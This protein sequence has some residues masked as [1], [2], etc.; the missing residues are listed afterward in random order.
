MDRSITFQCL[1]PLR[2]LV[3]IPKTYTK[4]HIL[5]E[6]VQLLLK[7]FLLV[8]LSHKHENCKKPAHFAGSVILSLKNALV[9]HFES[10]KHTSTSFQVKHC[11]ADSR[12]EYFLTLLIVHFRLK[13]W[14]DDLLWERDKREEDVLR[15]K[16]LVNVEGHQGRKVVQAV[17]EVYDIHDIASSSDFE[18]PLNEIVLIGRFLNEKTLQ[19]SLQTCIAGWTYHCQVYNKVKFDKK[20]LYSWGPLLHFAWDTKIACWTQYIIGIWLQTQIYEPLCLSF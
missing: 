18:S 15:L 7:C 19:A 4:T 3:G 16:G 8:K 6:V 12:V 9:C 11:W 10:Q 1:L 2:P 17:Q 14:L 20:N 5:I 13:Q